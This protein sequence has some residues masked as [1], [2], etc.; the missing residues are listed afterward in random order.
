[1]FSLTALVFAHAH[2][3]AFSDL[4]GAW[5][6]EPTVL[7]ASIVAIALF[8]RAFVKLRR[9]GRRD[10]A[11]W[12]HAA[13]FLLGVGVLTLALVSPL[14]AIGDEYLLSAHMLQHAVIGDLAPALLVLGARGPLTLFLQQDIP[15]SRRTT[16]S[17]TTPKRSTTGSRTA[18]CPATAAG[19]KTT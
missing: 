14:D 19:K 2:E 16:T 5:S 10:H 17:A 8:A 4:L 18:R 12:T 6:P 9:R 3:T 11:G 7:V 1:V 15:T 13:P